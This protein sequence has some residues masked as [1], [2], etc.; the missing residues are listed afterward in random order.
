MNAQNV[1]YLYASGKTESFVAQFGFRAIELEMAQTMK[2]ALQDRARENKPLPVTLLFV[3]EGRVIG[4][5][6]ASDY[7]SSARLQNMAFLN[8]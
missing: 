7:S 2:E 6:S 3:E 8:D 4:Q 1:I 5:L